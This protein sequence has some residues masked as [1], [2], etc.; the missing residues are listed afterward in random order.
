MDT[1]GGVAVTDQD[2][3]QAATSTDLDEPTLASLVA[4]GVL[5]PERAA[6]LRAEAELSTEAPKREE[7][8]E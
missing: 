7:S 8:A 6:A 4:S 3:R 5:S 2:L 1:C